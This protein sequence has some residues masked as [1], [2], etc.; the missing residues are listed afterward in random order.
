MRLFTRKTNIGLSILYALG[1]A[2]SVYTLYQLPSEMVQETY[3]VNLA[4]LSKMQPVLNGLYFTVGLSLALG[5]L[6][7]AALWLSQDRSSKKMVTSLVR[8]ET[9]H[10]A[11]EKPSSALSET[12]D[13]MIDGIIEKIEDQQE[14]AILFTEVL[15]QVC[16]QLEASQA[17]VYQTKHTDDYAYLALLASFAYHIPEGESI[18]YRLG[19]GLAGQAAKDGN[20]VNISAVPEGY[21]QIISGLGKATPSHLIIIP[22]KQEEEVWG[23]VEIASFKEFSPAQEQSLQT[24]FNNLTQKLANND[25]VSLAEAQQ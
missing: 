5:L 15:S 12:T 10:A 3:A 6:L 9:D 14:P 16:K 11:E 13:L 23:V 2:T 7:I 19:E 4:Q 24:L 18:T 20:L 1:V 8:E 21:L 25:N 22:M 17:A